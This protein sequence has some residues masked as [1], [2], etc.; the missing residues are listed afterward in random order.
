VIVAVGLMMTSVGTVARLTMRE[1]GEVDRTM[2]AG[3]VLLVSVDD[4]ANTRAFGHQVDAG[5]C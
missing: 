5:R 4:D 1:D 2:A 3:D